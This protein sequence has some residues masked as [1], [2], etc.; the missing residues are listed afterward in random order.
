MS[1]QGLKVA[2]LTIPI[3]LLDKKP[4]KKPQK[5][6]KSFVLGR[7]HLHLVWRRTLRKTMNDSSPLLMG[8]IVLL[9]ALEL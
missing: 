3:I 2:F 7:G 4:T 1:F 9:H 5:M 6:L 8:K